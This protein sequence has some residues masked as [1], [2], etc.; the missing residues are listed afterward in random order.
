MPN[1]LDPI[2]IANMSLEQLLLSRQWLDAALALV[3]PS[4][5][6][7]HGRR[8]RSRLSE[9]D[10]ELWYRLVGSD[11]PWSKRDAGRPN[12]PADAGDPSA[13]EPA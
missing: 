13:K 8:L 12:K 2:E 11:C 9:V 1:A 10:I 5:A 7:A 4:S 6:G 3:S